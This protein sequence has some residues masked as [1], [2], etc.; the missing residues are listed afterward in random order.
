[1][2]LL[3]H[4][5]DVDLVGISLGLAADLHGAGRLLM[6][7]ILRHYVCVFV[8]WNDALGDRVARSGPSRER[9]ES[10]GAYE[11]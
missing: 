9:S 7:G 10:L 3:E 5:V 8:S 4:L 6:S 11:S 1:M 2:D